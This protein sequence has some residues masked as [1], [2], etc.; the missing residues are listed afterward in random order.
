VD[1]TISGAGQLGAGQ[2]TLINNGTI[3]AI[4]THALVIDTGQNAV[5]NSGT[6]EATGSGGLVVNSDVANSGLLWANGGDITI[7]GAVAGSGSAAISGTATLEFGSASS[8]D[9]TFTADSVGTLVLGDPGDF[10]GTI[11]G[12]SSNDHIDLSNISYSTASVYSVTYSSSSNTTTLVVTDGTSADT[13]N[14][15]GN[16]A[17]NTVWNFASDGQGGTF[18]FESPAIPGHQESQAAVAMNTDNYGLDFDATL[19]R[20]HESGSAMSG[21]GSAHDLGGRLQGLNEMSFDQ[22]IFQTLAD[23]LAGAEQAHLDAVAAADQN[24][25]A[26]SMS[27]QTDKP[28]SDFIV[29]TIHS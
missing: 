12:L 11:T 16:Y 7:N 14:L 9:V 2:L 8:T 13:I 6:L 15:A 26:A 17:M 5:I 24:H 4:G 23:I 22:P 1:N 21:A 19:S 20:T 28:L 10:T 3:I 29:H 25:A 18:V 27:P